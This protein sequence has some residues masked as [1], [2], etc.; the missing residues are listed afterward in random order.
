M[1]YS[2]DAAHR[3]MLRRSHSAFLRLACTL[4]PRGLCGKLRSHLRSQNVELAPK[5]R[6]HAVTSAN[7]H[8]AQHG[9]QAEFLEIREREA[10]RPFDQDRQFGGCRP[11]LRIDLRT[12]VLEIGAALGGHRQQE[13][14]LAV[15][16]TRPIDDR[17]IE[18]L[19]V[20]RR[21]KNEQPTLGA[22]PSIWFKNNDR[23]ASVTCA[24]KSSKTSAQGAVC[25][26]R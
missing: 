16:P 11:Q 7:L 15:E 26:A 14:V 24:S 6:K 3:A 9:R 2:V 19:R 10:V 5:E 25:R 8:P 18:P 23:F 12:P 20:I 13:V 21:R 4:L 22:N 17:W 1:N